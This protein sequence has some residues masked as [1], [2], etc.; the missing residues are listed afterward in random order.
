MLNVV[1]AACFVGF[2]LAALAVAVAPPGRRRRAVNALLLY[3]MLVSFGAG[4]SQHDAWPFAKWPMAG[5]LADVDASN[6]RVVGVDA[7]GVE[8]AIDYRAW[9]P[10]GFDELNPWMHRTFPRLPRAEQ[11]RV[12]AFLRDLAERARQRAQAGRGVGYFHR[13]LGPL[14]APYFDLH[15]GAWD[16]GVPAQPFSG[17]RVY[18]ESWNQEER[19][20]DP[21]RVTRRLVYDLA[22]P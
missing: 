8:H 22:A 13:F 7:S 20:R 2:L 21:A 17:L 3:S 11:E 12:A 5:G 9:Q 18:R 19:R 14:A 10:L 16:A 4:L 15:P 6:T 1:S